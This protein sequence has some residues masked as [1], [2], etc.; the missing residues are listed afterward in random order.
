[1]EPRPATC[2]RSN[3]LSTGL[4]LR[5]AAL[6]M[7]FS[8]MAAASFSRRTNPTFTLPKGMLSS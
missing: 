2:H 4:A 6:L 3:I 8:A 5:S 7:S 1:M